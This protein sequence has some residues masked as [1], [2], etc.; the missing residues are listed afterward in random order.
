MQNVNMTD[1]F[2]FLIIY[3]SS[4]ASLQ[5][6]ESDSLEELFEN[7]ELENGMNNRIYGGA[8]AKP[9]K[10]FYLCFE[11]SLCQVNN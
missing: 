2:I 9:R 4:S 1:I 7:I 3:V 8:E 11:I 6:S 5:S 10:D